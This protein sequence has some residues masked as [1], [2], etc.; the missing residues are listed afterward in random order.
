[1]TIGTVVPA[2][3]RATVRVVAS[4]SLPSIEIL[5]SAG[6]LL[7]VMS[8]FATL[9]GAALAEAAADALADDEV[10]VPSPGVCARR[11]SCDFQ[12]RK[13]PVPII[14]ANTIPITAARTYCLLL[15]SS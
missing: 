9:A 13:L 8:L 6:V 4:S 1:M 12:M 14:T 15:V 2:A 3:G 11:I 7:N 5:A 10:F